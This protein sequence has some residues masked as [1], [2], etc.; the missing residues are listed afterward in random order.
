MQLLKPKLA[1]K[2]LNPL[3]YEDNSDFEQEANQTE[4]NSDNSDD[5]TKKFIN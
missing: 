4:V 5:E 2:R 3:G 1:S